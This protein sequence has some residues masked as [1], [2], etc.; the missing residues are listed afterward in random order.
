MVVDRESEMPI[1]GISTGMAC[2]QAIS[3]IQFLRIRG[4]YTIQCD[5]EIR[6]GSNS[7]RYWSL[8]SCGMQ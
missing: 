4:G 1:G 7:N 6:D 8:Y 2:E 5:Y 3:L